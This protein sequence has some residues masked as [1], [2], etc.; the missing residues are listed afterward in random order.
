M[1]RIICKEYPHAIRELTC[2][3]FEIFCLPRGVLRE[4]DWC[5]YQKHGFERPHWEEVLCS[6]Y[7][8]DD[9]QLHILRQMDHLEQYIN[10]M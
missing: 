2:R 1:G 8:P 7:V 6:N 9:L 4:L 10:G 5:V 3:A